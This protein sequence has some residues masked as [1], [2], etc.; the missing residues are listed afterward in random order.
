[1]YSNEF[2]IIPQHLIKLNKSEYSRV[3]SNKFEKKIKWNRMKAT[4]MK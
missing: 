2:V 3:T 4:E 1:M